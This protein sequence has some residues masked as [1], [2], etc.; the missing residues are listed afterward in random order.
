LA[1]DI[2]NPRTNPLRGK[3]LYVLAALLIEEYHEHIKM[4]SRKTAGG[5]EKRKTREATSALEGLLEEDAIATEESKLIDN[6][7]RGAEGYH[8][9]LLAQKQLYEGYIEASMKTALHLREY[10]D[11]IDASCIFSLLALVSCA[12]R[13]FGTCSKAFIKLELLDHIT[14]EQQQAYEDLALEIFT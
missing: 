11:V 3:K 7:W 12:N 9:F 1:K 10:E 6:A 8:F 5:G 14:D 4:S 13:S 2:A